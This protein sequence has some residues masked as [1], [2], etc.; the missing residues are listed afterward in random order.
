VEC[1]EYRDHT[2]LLG[3][4]DFKEF[5][6]L[7]D[8]MDGLARLV[9]QDTQ[10]QLGQLVIKVPLAGQ[11]QPVGLV[12]PDQLE[13]REYV[14]HKDTK[15]L[16]DTREILEHKDQLVLLVLT[17]LSVQLVLVDNLDL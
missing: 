10:E 5:R 15:E 11:V 9:R 3:P 16:K 12:Q 6:G 13:R 14:E 4:Q 8:N 2:D 17:V 1:K 7:L